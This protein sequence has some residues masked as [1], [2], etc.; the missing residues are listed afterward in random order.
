MKSLASRHLFPLLAGCAGLSAGIFSPSLFQNPPPPPTEHP[1]S[2]RQ[3]A[4]ERAAKSAHTPLPVG[5]TS[6]LIQDLE[7]ASAS[8]CQ[9]LV[10]AIFQAQQPGKEI[11]LEAIFKRWLKSENIDAILSHLESLEPPRDSPWRTALFHAWASTD[12]IAAMDR[13]KHHNVFAAA[14]ALF[15][16]QS[17]NPSFTDY[18]QGTEN[19]FS[20]QDRAVVALAQLARDHPEIASLVGTA[21]IDD[22][23]KTELIAAVAKGWASHDPTAALAWLKSINAPDDALVAV[24]AEWSTLDP[25][26]AASAIKALGLKDFAHNGE[27]TSRAVDALLDPK[28]SNSRIAQAILRD[29]FLDV[30]DIHRI[31]TESQTD[32]RFLYLEFSNDG[33]QPPD[34][35]A[36]ILQANALPPGKAR[37]SILEQLLRTW[38]QEDLQAAAAFANQHGL[39][40]ES[41]NNLSESAIPP[42]LREAARH[43]PAETLAPLFEDPSLTGPTKSHLQTLATEWATTD[44]ESAAKWS[45]GDI[46]TQND[47]SWSDLLNSHQIARIAAYRWSTTDPLAATRWVESLPDDQIRSK[48][49]SIM[50]NNIGS[51]SPDLAFQNSAAWVNEKDRFETLEWNLSQVITK[52]GRPAAINLLQSADLTTQERATLSA[53]LNPA[54]GE[55]SR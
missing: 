22:S 27:I 21:E 35:P 32:N 43:S 46:L 14:R 20:F 51:Y 28:N 26:A 47:T 16:I 25:T 41:I 2:P 7:N 37:D 34:L 12:E 42:D 29:P 45:V 4:A 17:A 30:T 44:P 10:H 39:E 18:F 3:R 31:L 55:P 5:P 6:Q 50:A 36:A 1:L 9:H 8:D 48:M 54:P 52:I 33:W 13:S 24:F 38:A 19:S 11:E 49:W 15:A 40:S 23:L 53:T